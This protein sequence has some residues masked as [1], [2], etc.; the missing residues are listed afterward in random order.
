VRLVRYLKR[1][2]VSLAE[3]LTFLA[4]LVHVRGPDGASILVTL[5]PIMATSLW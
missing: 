2:Q 3:A 5:T 1:K 4:A